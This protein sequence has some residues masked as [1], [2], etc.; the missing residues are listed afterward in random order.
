MATPPAASSPAFERA[1]SHQNLCPTGRRS[2]S[3]FVIAL[4]PA[5]FTSYFRLPSP[6]PD[7][8]APQSAQADAFP[9]LRQKQRDLLQRGRPADATADIAAAPVRDP[10][11]HHCNRNALPCT[12]IRFGQSSL[13]IRMIK[14]GCRT[15]DNACTKLE[16]SGGRTPVSRR[17]AHQPTAAPSQS[18]RRRLPL[19][20]RSSRTSSVAA[21]TSPTETA[22]SHTTFRPATASL[23]PDGIT[24]SRPLSPARYRPLVAMRA[25][26]HGAPST[27]TA[28]SSAPRPP[29]PTHPPF[30]FNSPTSEDDNQLA[31]E[32]HNPAPADDSF[33]FPFPPARSHSPLSRSQESSP[34]RPA[35]EYPP[36]R[37]PLPI[38]SPSPST[39]PNPPTATSSGPP[40]I[41]HPHSVRVIITNDSDA[42]LDLNEVRMQFIS[43]NNDKIPPR[44]RRHQ[45]PPLLPQSG[46]RNKGPLSPPFRFIRASSTRRS[47]R[48]TIYLGFKSTPWLLPTSAGYLLRRQGPRRRIQLAVCMRCS[49]R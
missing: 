7:S 18:W 17:T 39:L 16:I 24:P 38:T 22:C 30:L 2:A 9:A 29:G 34:A 1:S 26:H 25:S 13:S 36:R 46:P 44:P 42:P 45:P 47:P 15:S 41:R 14:L 5:A 11:I 35:A 21:I 40:Y 10:R 8:L 33:A 12:S 4:S 19:R 28:A 49:S 3:S 31:H 43:A 6:L 48:T 27:T 23:S 32:S 20:Q 37:P